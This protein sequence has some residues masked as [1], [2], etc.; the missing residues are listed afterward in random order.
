M[1]GFLRRKNY[2]L[3]KKKDR[4]VVWLVIQNLK[5]RTKEN[6]LPVNLNTDKITF[7]SK[8]HSSCGY[9]LHKII[10]SL[11]PQKQLVC[12]DT[13]LDFLLPRD[14]QITQTVMKTDSPIPQNLSHRN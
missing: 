8:C 10:A 9:K 2:I 13:K 12:H 14:T 4:T 11:V 3:G 7:C 5:T 6:T 1:S